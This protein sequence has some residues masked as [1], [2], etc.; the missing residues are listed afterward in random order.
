MAR[1]RVPQFLGILY[2][3][4]LLYVMKI[5][6]I[7]YTLFLLYPLVHKC[8]G[9]YGN[10]AEKDDTGTHHGHPGAISVRTRLQ[11][12][13]RSHSL[14]FL[15]GEFQKKKKKKTMTAL[16]HYQKLPRIMETTAP[17]VMKLLRKWY[18]R[19]SA[20]ML[21][22]LCCAVKA[23]CHKGHC[24]SNQSL[25]PPLGIHQHSP[26]WTAHRPWN[27]NIPWIAIRGSPIAAPVHC[28][29]YLNSNRYSV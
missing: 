16:N 29:V 4:T 7:Y 2:L 22:K 17:T 18:G 8:P 24:E 10:S 5:H 23:V 15:K 28:G 27:R 13:D 19:S 21:I 6:D 1:P 26:L 9:I 3:V 14:W 20:L 12:H 25:V 11:K